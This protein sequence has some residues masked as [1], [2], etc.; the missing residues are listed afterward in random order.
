MSYV[1]FPK[2]SPLD[3]RGG[4]FDADVGGVTGDNDLFRPNW[5]NGRFLTAEALRTQDGYWEQRTQMLAQV[6][7]PGVAWGLGVHAENDNQEILLE[8]GLAFNGIGQ[9][10]WVSKRQQI[11]VEKLLVSSSPPR[12]VVGGANRLVSGVSLTPDNMASVAGAGAATGAYLL[13]IEPY[14]R[15]EG[16]AKVYG[17]VCA[18]P[19][20][21]R[22]EANGSRCGYRLSLARLEVNVSDYNDKWQRRGELAAYYFDELE[23]NL[24]KRWTHGF[25]KD[26]KTWE[27]GGSIQE[28]G[29]AV[30]LAVL[31]FD[32]GEMEFLDPWIPRR[33]LVSTRAASRFSNLLGGPTPA[34]AIARSHQFQYQLAESLDPSALGNK[35]STNL[36]GRGFRHIPPVGFLPVTAS[37]EEQ[38]ECLDLGLA[39]RFSVN[40]LTGNYSNLVAGVERGVCHHFKG[41]NILPYYVV[42][43]NDDDILEDIGRSFEQDPIFVKPVKNLGT[44]LTGWLSGFLN[45]CLNGNSVFFTR[46]G[47][48][49]WPCATCF[50]S[51]AK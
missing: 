29:D 14:D 49:E 2:A 47:L 31:C 19:K 40:G 33:P 28:T 39:H 5:F 34:A 43:V 6:Y 7:A 32:G 35:P 30:P 12:V 22:C 1:F 8:R 42:T 51:I 45:L 26:K 24:N 15:F 16:Q 4:F 11:K 9:P 3:Y 38:E 36:Y 48:P 13:V 27:A 20:T 17:E 10:I 18:S 23:H 37:K 41:T 46:A 50:H 21:V 44:N 25:A